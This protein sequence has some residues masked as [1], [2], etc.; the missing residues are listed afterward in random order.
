MAIFIIQRGIL[1][2]L[3]LHGGILLECGVDLRF[4]ALAAT[5]IQLVSFQSKHKRP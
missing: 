3:R 2:T 5:A 1:D 4:S